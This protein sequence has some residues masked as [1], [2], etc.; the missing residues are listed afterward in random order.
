MRDLWKWKMPT[1]TE[2]LTKIFSQYVFQI[3]SVVDSQILMLMTTTGKAQML[4][5]YQ[6]QD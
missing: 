3:L 6:T 1:E 5:M 4:E 2:C